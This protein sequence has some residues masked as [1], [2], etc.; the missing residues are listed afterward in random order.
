M[1]NLSDQDIEKK[2]DLRH[3]IKTIQFV[4]FYL[5]SIDEVS[6]IQFTPIQKKKKKK[7]NSQY[8]YRN[9][10]T[11]EE[12]DEYKIT[13]YCPQKIYQIIKKD[14]LEMFT[15]TITETQSMTLEFNKKIPILAYERNP[16]VSYNNET[17]ISCLNLAAFYGSEQIFNYILMN[18]NHPQIE[19]VTLRMAFMGGN[20]TIIRK[21][22]DMIKMTIA[23]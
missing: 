2:L 18:L 23:Y 14:D 16:D 1:K 3:S 6:Q 10:F 20:I 15:E 5:S 22:I 17:D 8:G 11:D 13:G 7:K 4:L 21:C 19:Y 9:E 12:L